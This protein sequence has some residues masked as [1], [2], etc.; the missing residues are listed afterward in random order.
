MSFDVWA[1]R[2]RQFTNEVA[3]ELDKDPSS[4]LRI[5]T[6]SLHVLRSR[7]TAKEG[8]DLVA[9]LPMF[10]KA[11]WMDG[12]DPMRVPD[13]SLRRRDEFVQ[14][15][16]EHPGIVVPD[17]F[18]NLED[19]EACIMAVFDVVKRHVSPGETADVRAQLPKDIL[20]LW[21]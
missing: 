19:A 18:D 9:Q 13:K 8:A 15:V 16:I 17:D 4:A 20:P 3:R 11:I 1:Q 6:A 2:A 21:D 12:W 10:V 5:M 14:R 7:L